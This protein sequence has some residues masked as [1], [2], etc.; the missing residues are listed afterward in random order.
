MKTQTK[1][2]TWTD[3]KKQI[4]EFSRDGLIDL[5][6]DLYELSSTNKTFLNTRFLSTNIQQSLE[7]FKQHIQKPFVW[8]EIPQSLD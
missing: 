7:P 6:K 3:V 1:N 4:K 8:K 2:Q 5:V